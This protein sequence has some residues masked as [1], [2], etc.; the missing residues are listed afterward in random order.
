MPKC[1]HPCAGRNSIALRCVD[2]FADYEMLRF[3]EKPLLRCEEHVFDVQ[4]LPNG[5]VI[6]FLQ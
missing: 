2:W 3:D 6:K 1:Q 4:A 5:F